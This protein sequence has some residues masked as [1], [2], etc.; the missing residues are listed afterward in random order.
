MSPDEMY[1]VIAAFQQT[2]PAGMNKEEFA[3]M[4]SKLV[5]SHA[6]KQHFVIDA[7]K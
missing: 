5:P 2:Y 6:K 4:L 7:F 3:M 1:N